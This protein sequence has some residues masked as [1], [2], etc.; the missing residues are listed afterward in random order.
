MCYAGSNPSHDVSEI[1][2]GE[3]LWQ[4]FR[5]QIKRNAFRRSTIPQKQLTT[6]TIIIIIM[7]IIITFD[8]VVPNNHLNM[9]NITYI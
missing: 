5:L 2:D 7:I 4:W 6:T 9:F 8:E 3:N 1:C